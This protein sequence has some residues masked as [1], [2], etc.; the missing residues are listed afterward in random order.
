MASFALLS[1]RPRDVSITMV[2]PLMTRSLSG[3]R[4]S[5]HLIRDM[6]VGIHAGHVVEVFEALDKAHDRGCLV[7]RQLDLSL[8]HHSHLGAGHY[9][10]SGFEGAPNVV[11]L[12][13]VRQ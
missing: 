2:F 7:N 13:R 3:R 9:R 11:E 6:N 4:L 12:S 8:G 1:A 5:E 10:S